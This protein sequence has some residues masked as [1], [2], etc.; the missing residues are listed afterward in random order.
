V[1]TA[2]GGRLRVA[3][4][5]EYGRMAVATEGLPELKN[6]TYQ[7]WAVRNDVSTSVGLI[8]N[9][10]V[11]KVMPIPAAGTTVAITIEPAGGSR[12]PTHRP[13]IQMDPEEV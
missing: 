9:L 10:K 12:Q 13:I 3:T 8:D 6:Q 4:S 5:A 11:G 2:N 1:T 7:M